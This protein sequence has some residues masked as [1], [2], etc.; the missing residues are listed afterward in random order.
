MTDLFDL[1]EATWPP[2]ACRR[3]G[4]FAIRDGAGGGKR[5]SAATAEAPGAEAAIDLAEAAIAASGQQP[6]FL[7]RPG[8]D[9]LDAALASRGYSVLDPTLL[10]A[11]PTADLG[12]PPGPLAAFAHWPPL[13]IVTQIWAEAGLGPAR[14]AV[15][16][17]V[18]GPRTAILGRSRDRPAG[19]VFVATRGN[20][21][22]LH[23]LE[24]PAALRR[25]GTGAVLVRAAAAWADGQGASR[26]VLAV[27]EANAPARA[28]YASLGMEVVGRYH[29]RAR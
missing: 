26:L 10:Y 12:P 2:A 1:L 27:T 17:R 7:L 6:L 9:G 5:V 13:A 8:E 14:V 3:E 19:A 29:Y 20:L 4:P 25:Q 22:M 24:V 23:A 28:L 16:A 18:T 11:A 21:A 15:M